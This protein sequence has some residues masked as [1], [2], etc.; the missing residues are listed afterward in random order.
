MSNKKPFSLGL[1][2]ERSIRLVDTRGGTPYSVKGGR[3]EVCLNEVWGTVCGNNWDTQDT[4]VVCTQ[5]R[6]MT[7]GR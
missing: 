3:V 5:L 2:R 1:C 4:Q 7:S 6:Y